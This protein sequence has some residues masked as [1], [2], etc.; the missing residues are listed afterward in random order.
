MILT[1][2]LLSLGAP[3]ALAERPVQID[4]GNGFT[5]AV[6]DTGRIRCWDYNSDGQ[7]GDGTFDGDTRVRAATSGTARPTTAP[8]RCR[9]RGSATR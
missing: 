1:G 9:S 3:P 7:L 4:A 6:I 5:C 8:H 2:V